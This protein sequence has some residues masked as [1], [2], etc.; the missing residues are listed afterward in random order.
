MDE[1]RDRND[2]RPS[3]SPVRRSNSSPSL[4]E[5]TLVD[6]F[7]FFN[8]NSSHT[9]PMRLNGT[10]SRN[11]AEL[12]D[13][14][15]RVANEW[16]Y[17]CRNEPGRM[18]GRIRRG[19]PDVMRKRVWPLLLQVRGYRVRHPTIYKGLC[20]E[21]APLQQESNGQFSPAIQEPSRF[22]DVLRKL[23]G[24][25][26][27]NALVCFLSLYPWQR[28]VSHTSQPLCY[29]PLFSPRF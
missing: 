8:F 18:K 23:I 6:E 24:K 1:Q 3:P 12:L 4:V 21:F 29:H 27:I 26:A 14:W 17:L 2:I 22:R 15:N 28:H 19:I 13:K 25:K 10:Q 16:E 5:D 20:D 11:P 7:G 9:E